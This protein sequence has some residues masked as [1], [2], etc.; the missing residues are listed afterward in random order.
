VLATTSAALEH[1]RAVADLGAALRRA[2]HLV[3]AR[4]KLLAAFAAAERLGAL[5]LACLV[6][7]ELDA[8]GVRAPRTTDD[9]P[10]LTP[11]QRRVADLAARGLSNTEIAQALFVTPKTVEYHLS[12]VY[13]RL[14][15]PG[16]RHLA[17]A[18]AG[19]S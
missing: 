12:Q 8:A 15:V 9:R 5:R 3:E 11:S 18:L 16:R 17:A 6:R 4:P 2:G 7:E 1:T 10:L 14:Q 19:A 13:Q